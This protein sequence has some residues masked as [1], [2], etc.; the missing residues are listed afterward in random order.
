VESCAR[1]F[2]A[3]HL[4]MIVKVQG[5]RPDQP[6]ADK[7][8]QEKTGKG[9]NVS[10][11]KRWSL[12]FKA[13]LINSYWKSTKLFILTSGSSNHRGNQKSLGSTGVC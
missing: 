8:N 7:R 6:E 1:V 10:K 9:S 4:E 3:L 5:D 11:P 13:K 2:F 12:F